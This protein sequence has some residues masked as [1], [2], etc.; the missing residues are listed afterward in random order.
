MCDG[1][2]T[3]YVGD[4]GIASV[5]ISCI[6]PFYSCKTF[7]EFKRLGKLRSTARERGI[8]LILSRGNK[9][10]RLIPFNSFHFDVSLCGVSLLS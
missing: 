1:F 2:W 9:S 5:G 3:H 10:G 4:E 8:I 6:S 7:T